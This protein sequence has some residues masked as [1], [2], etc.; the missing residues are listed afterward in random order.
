MGKATNE[1][2]LNRLKFAILSGESWRAIPLTDG[3]FLVSNKGRLARCDSV[4]YWLVDPTKNSFGEFGLNLIVP[5]FSET[6][7][8][9]KVRDTYKFVSMQRI[10]AT[11]W[12]MEGENDFRV[13][14]HSKDPM[15]WEIE[16]LKLNYNSKPF[17]WLGVSLKRMGK[18]K[19]KK[20]LDFA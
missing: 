16:N 8:T 17:R 1:N 9:V 5:K 2:E 15:D 4:F 3:E 14:T 20:G 6:I 13:T 19:S 18:R 10:M 7:T 12:L 11:V